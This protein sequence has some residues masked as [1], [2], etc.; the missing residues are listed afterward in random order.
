MTTTTTT[1]TKIK[2]I[3]QQQQKQTNTNNKDKVTTVH[4]FQHLIHLH[5]FEHNTNFP[6]NSKVSFVHFLCLST[7]LI[8]EKSNKKIERKV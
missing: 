8:S 3:Q 7:G 1:T 2:N 6:S 5:H 4:W